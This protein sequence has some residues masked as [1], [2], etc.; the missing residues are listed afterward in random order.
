[1]P[2]SEISAMLEVVGLVT[3]YGRVPVLH[4][5]SLQVAEGA[6]VGVLGP[7]GAG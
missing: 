2:I 4:G 3:G 6:I 1:M 5:V 7:K